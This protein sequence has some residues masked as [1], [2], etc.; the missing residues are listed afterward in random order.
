MRLALLGKKQVHLSRTY[1]Y[2]YILAHL[3]I[4]FILQVIELAK[5]NNFVTKFTSMVVEA[6]DKYLHYDEPSSQTLADEFDC[7]LCVIHTVCRFECFKK[8]TCS[9]NYIKGSTNKIVK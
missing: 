6:K 1:I 5:K 7:P 8:A 3:Y 9:T 4:L 2:K